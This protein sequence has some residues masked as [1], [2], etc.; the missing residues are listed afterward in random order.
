MDSWI[1]E[2]V[3]AGV[4]AAGAVSGLIYYLWAKENPAAKAVGSSTSP[5]P[6]ETTVRSGLSRTRAALRG[7]FDSKRGPG[8]ASVWDELEDALLMAD[9][10][11]RTTRTLIDG[12]RAKTPIAEVSALR[13][14]LESEVAA[15]F[16]APPASSQPAPHPRVISVVGVNGVGKTTTVGK[17]AALFSQQGKSV[18]MGAVDTFRAA[19]TQQLQ[20]WA[21]RSGAQF[22]SGR[23][24]G[25]PGAV[26]FD[27]VTAGKA[28]G[29]DCVLLDTA[30]RL[31]TKSNLMDE[32][33]RVHRVIKKVIPDAPH[34]VWLVIDGTLGQNSLRQAEEFKK[35][36]EVTGVI[37]TKLDGT[38]K[39]G[40]L[41]AIAHDLGLP[42]KYIGL[43][44][45]VGDLQ[46]FE[47]KAFAAALFGDA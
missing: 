15:L 22:V 33:T 12:V 26:A 6:E 20:V 4:G 17:L 13:A 39:G 45:K 41:L 2:Y 47:P 24:G 31:H 16:V 5:A 42:V 32:L 21:E 35:A 38:A 46:P 28:R 7:F 23:E 40:A 3:L 14:S 1:V 11:V 44:E 18:L 34:E 43:G 8:T 36:I 10:G 9:V 29:I 30:G 27:A 25:D 19:A 37:V